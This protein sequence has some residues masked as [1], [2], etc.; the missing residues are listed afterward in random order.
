LSSVQEANNL[1]TTNFNCPTINKNPDSSQI[2]Q[3]KFDKKRLINKVTKFKANVKANQI[4][5]RKRLN[6]TK[7]QL[8]EANEDL[9]TQLTNSRNQLLCELD[10]WEKLCVEKLGMFVDSQG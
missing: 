4:G 3:L 6:E 1:T 5:Y 10:E 9:I 2:S 8:K 7:K